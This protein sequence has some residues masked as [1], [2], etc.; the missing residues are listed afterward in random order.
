MMHRSFV[1]V[2]IALTLV[3]AGCG[4]SPQRTKEN[5]QTSDIREEAAPADAASPGIAVSSAPG[6]AFNYRYAFRVPN[7]KISAVQEEHAQACEKLGLDRCRITGMRY[8]LVSNDEVSAMLSFKLDPTLAREFGKQGIAAVT[9]AEGMLVDS[10]ITGTDAGAVIEG[11]NRA[12]AGLRDEL[13]KVEEQLKR[14]GLSAGERTELTQQAA[15]LREQ[16]RSASATRTDARESLAT[17]PMVFDYGSGDLIPGFDGA[18]PI[19]EAFRTASGT[20]VTMLGFVVIAI[21]ALLPWA[22]LGGLG[23]WV[24]RLIRKARTAKQN[25]DAAVA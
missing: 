21:G 22:L 14:S 16:I 7:A 10:E 2:P 8:R 3:L 23:V 12:S 4:Q 1:L 6:V 24:Y 9:K 5:L 19:R 20:F 13:A 17:T 15:S 18:S 11:A 25:S